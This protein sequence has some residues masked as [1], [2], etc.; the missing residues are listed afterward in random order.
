MKSNLVLLLLLSLS[1]LNISYQNSIE[2]DGNIIEQCTKCDTGENSNK[3]SICEDGTFP[4]FHNLL[5]LPCNHS[6]YG[7][8]G[9]EKKMPFE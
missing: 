7:I 5:C 8:S 9:C 1:L 4:F 6:E 2:C 3:C